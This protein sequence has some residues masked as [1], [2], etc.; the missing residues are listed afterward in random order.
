[1]PPYGAGSNPNPSMPDP[2]TPIVTALALTSDGS[3][4][5]IVPQLSAPSPMF[6]VALNAGGQV[7]FASGIQNVGPNASQVTITVRTTSSVTPVGFTGLPARQIAAVAM[8]MH[9]TGTPIPMLFV[10]S[11]QPSVL[12]MFAKLG[13]GPTYLS[14]GNVPISGVAD[15]GFDMF[16]TTTPA[17][18]ACASCHPEGGDDGHIWH[19]VTKDV[20]LGDGGCPTPAFPGQPAPAVLR[21]TQSLRGGILSTAPLHWDGDMAGMGDIVT[22]VFTRRMSGG[23]VTTDQRAVFSR[24][25]DSI[26]RMP[27][28]ADLDSAR[29]ASGRALFE[30]KGECASCH[31]GSKLT[32]N[33]TVDVGRG[34][35]QVPML[36]GVGARAPFIHDGC[37]TTLAD[38]FDPSCGGSKHGAA[39]S[40]DETSDVVQYLESL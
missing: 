3:S 4:F 8:S 38:R 12:A 36:L 15:T 26:P 20:V 39:L 14:V 9:G 25:I 34:A 27:Q 22:E 40:P 33:A 30:G 19:F 13:N 18:I 37:A 24:W 21:R 29:V 1:M 32:N 28:R 2:K 23:V 16:H 6:D 17:G 10:Q 5:Q 7:A 31:S 35:L 11:R